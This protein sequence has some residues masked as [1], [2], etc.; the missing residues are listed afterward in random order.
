MALFTVKQGGGAMYTTI[1]A[2]LAA[3][4]Y[5][6]LGDGADDIVEIQ[7]DAVYVEHLINNIPSGTGW[8]N[9]FTLRAGAGY[10]PTIRNNDPFTPFSRNVTMWT[11]IPSSFYSIFEGLK[12]DGSNISNDSVNI[13]VSSVR[14]NDC[15]FVNTETESAIY[16][17]NIADDVQLIRLHIHGGDFFTTSNSFGHNHAV[18]YTGSNGLIEDCIFH[19]LPGWGL[20]MYYSGSAPYPSDNIVQG[21]LVYDYGKLC[22]SAAGILVTS[23]ERNQVRYNVVRDGL[24]LSGNGAIGIDIAGS[25][26]EVYHNTTYNNSWYG[27]FAANSTNAIIKNNI[28]YANGTDFEFAGA[29]G[30]TQSNNLIGTDPL[31]VDEEARDFHLQ[32]G[33]PA[34]DYGVDV[35]LGAGRDAGAYEFG[36][37]GEGPPEDP[38]FP[39]P[40][41]PPD[42]PPEEPEDP[43]D[44]P[45]YEPPPEEVPDTEPDADPPTAPTDPGI[46][47]VLDCVAVNTRVVQKT[48]EPT[49]MYSKVIP[50]Y[51][52]GDRNSLRLSLQL[53]CCS[54]RRLCPIDTPP[55][56][57]PLSVVDVT[58]KPSGGYSSFFHVGV[59]NGEEL[60][61]QGTS[62]P[63]YLGIY[64]GFW[65][66]KHRG[67]HNPSQVQHNFIPFGGFYVHTSGG[68]SNRP[69]T[70]NYNGLQLIDPLTDDFTGRSVPVDG[71]GSPRSIRDNRLYAIY[72]QGNVGGSGPVSI[73]KHN[74]D[75]NPP[76]MM[77]TNNDIDEYDWITTLHAATNFLYAIGYKSGD[78][79]Y[80]VKMDLDTLDILDEFP[81]GAP[82]HE[83]MFAVSDNL[84]IYTHQTSSVGAFAVW[85]WEG[86]VGGNAALIDDAV[87]NMVFWTPSAYNTPFALLKHMYVQLIGSSLWLYINSDAS[88]FTDIAK[89]GPI[90]CP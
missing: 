89:I 73:R 28:A 81:I 2:A 66:F 45:P 43:E 70:F 83:M 25:D 10:T 33:S 44:P 42:P 84:I 62:S 35:G 64:D 19:D 41:D 59:A 57:Q 27:I 30:L 15:E 37:G 31:F 51:T 74:L 47:R 54:L 11:V 77:V 3:V 50:A 82:K 26:Q 14:V 78:Q 61:Y 4:G 80:I 38:P 32:A 48:F 18:Y 55:G 86:G 56:R 16:V 53:G 24:A 63:F 12:F 23:G 21:N 39:P 34:I 49:V 1:S 79:D 8:G 52:L 90:N 36:G 72:G 76:E 65:V 58:S 40:D 75:V 88:E 29:T 60:M 5:S 85:Y 46:V 69:A 20:H 13:A 68:I 87:A 6:T 9:P 22:N 17:S 67:M 71:W 7:D